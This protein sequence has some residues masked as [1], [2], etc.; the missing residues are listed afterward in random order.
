MSE[1][2]IC[3][4]RAYLDICYIVRSN[5]FTDQNFTELES[6]L[7]RFHHYR[8]IFRET[9]VRVNGFSL[10]CQHALVHYASLIRLFGAPNGLCTSITESKHITAVKKPWQWSN[11]HKA[12]G[13]MLQTNQR[14][15]F[16]AASRADFEAHSML[17][18]SH[19]AAST[20]KYLFSSGRLANQTSL[21]PQV[22]LSDKREDHLEGAVDNCPGLAHS[23]VKLASKAGEFTR[24]SYLGFTDTLTSS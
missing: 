17:P 15:S 5:F 20:S 21:Q 16:P 2:M 24:F 22:E 9:R 6:A 1:D 11:K 13:Q 7:S 4:F 8:E 10:P 18:R 12:I 19:Q 14:L 23:D 3:T